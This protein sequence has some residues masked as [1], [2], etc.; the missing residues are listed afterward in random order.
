MKTVWSE[1]GLLSYWRSR[2][3]FRAEQ[4]AQTLT[5]SLQRGLLPKSGGSVC[6]V[7]PC[8]TWGSQEGSQGPGPSRVCAQSCVCSISK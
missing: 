4:E 6:P 5:Y 8:G 7:Q 1:G 2:A 3:A